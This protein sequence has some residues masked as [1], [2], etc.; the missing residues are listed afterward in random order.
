[1]KKNETNCLNY[2]VAPLIEKESK[3]IF[4]TS[5]EIGCS[6]I[7]LKQILF[8][9]QTGKFTCLKCGSSFGYNEF[10]ERSKP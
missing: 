6:I 2:G 4:E 3:I 8:D 5:F 7:Y 10:L 1:M 9:S